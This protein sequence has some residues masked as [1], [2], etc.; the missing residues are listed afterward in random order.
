MPAA[1]RDDIGR[2]VDGLAQMGFLAASRPTSSGTNPMITIMALARRTA[3]AI[4][5]ASPAATS[6]TA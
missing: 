2:S 6:I 1:Q 5:A 3:E 4:V